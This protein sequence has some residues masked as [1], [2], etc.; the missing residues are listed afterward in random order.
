MGRDSFP[1]LPL[2]C[3]ERSDWHLAANPH[4][5][6]PTADTRQ[7]M[8]SH[9]NSTSVPPHLPPAHSPARAVKMVARWL[10]LDEDDA[11][12]LLNALSTGA[13]YASPYDVVLALRVND[14]WVA[15]H[16]VASAAAVVDAVAAAS[17]AHIVA[18]GGFHA[19]RFASFEA[20][21]CCRQAL[22]T[23]FP[24]AFAKPYVYFTEFADA[25]N[26]KTVAPIAATAVV[27]AARLWDEDPFQLNLF[28]T[29]RD[30]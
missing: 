28:D 22:M 2:C 29:R 20:L 9:A 17:S 26:A 6:Q 1:L 19:F 24:S 3:K 14:A 11:L 15:A 10:A 27:E 8:L 4:N 18:R 12:A 21:R 23:R 30:K 7:P 25:D 13:A 5:R 16:D